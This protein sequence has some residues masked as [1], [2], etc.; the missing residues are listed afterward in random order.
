MIILE[1]IGLLDKIPLHFM[2]K[3]NF[4]V[5]MNDDVKRG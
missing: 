5:S 2:D 3:I 1:G 4:I